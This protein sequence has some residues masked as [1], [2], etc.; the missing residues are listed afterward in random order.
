MYKSYYAS[1]LGLIEVVASDHFVE[2]V[3]FVE[4]KDE[5]FIE[6]E[7]TKK[8]VSEL[9]EYFAKKRYQF[10]IP[11]RLKVTKFQEKVYQE[12]LKV[13][14]GRTQT[15]EGI[16][17]N[18]GSVSQAR[19]VGGAISK[20]PLLFLIPCHRIIGS[21]GALVGYKAGLDIKKKLLVFE[22]SLE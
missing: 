14:Y 2:E 10:D 15:Y 18:I 22:N 12:V 4:V 1:E 6:S 20:N 7:L 9:I 5:K 3:N 17:K 21:N 19:A 8:C 16:A 13:P 11:F